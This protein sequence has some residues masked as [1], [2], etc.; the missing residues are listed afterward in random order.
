MVAIKLEQLVKNR[1]PR[2]GDYAL[3]TRLDVRTKLAV[4]S[5]P[6][7]FWASSYGQFTAAPSFWR[8]SHMPLLCSEVQTYTLSRSVSWA[9][10][11]LIYTDTIPIPSN[12]DPTS[13]ENRLK[14]PGT[15]GNVSSHPTPGKNTHIPVT[16]R[17]KKVSV[18]LRSPVWI[19]AS[20]LAMFSRRCALQYSCP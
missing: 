9:I 5:L 14:R 16:S 1:R 17:A 10:C 7:S 19:A 11:C 15:R 4:R 8:Q 20:R 12:I 13:L 3:K 2:P 6:C 18:F